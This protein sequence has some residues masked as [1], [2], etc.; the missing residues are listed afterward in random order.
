MRASRGQPSARGE[1]GGRPGSDQR[2]TEGAR[3][4]RASSKGGGWRGKR[5]ARARPVGQYATQN[6]RPGPGREPGG[7]QPL[8]KPRPMPRFPEARGRE[9]RGLSH[10][11]SP[12]SR[13]SPSGEGRGGAWNPHP[14]TARGTPG[15][16]LPWRHS[17]HPAP[18]R[19]LASGVAVSA[20]AG[21]VRPDAPRPQRGR[22]EGAAGSEGK[23]GSAGL[24]PP[25][26][27]EKRKWP[28]RR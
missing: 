11:H 1:T 25:E 7:R 13:K 14:A 23:P 18:P 9:G 28:P 16:A 12:G 21:L 10:A 6:N 4:E 5:R 17:G 2:D 22:F 20:L 24:C 26:V 15:W 3:P 8:R 19:A 27:G